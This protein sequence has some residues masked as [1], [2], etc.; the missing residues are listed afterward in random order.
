MIEELAGL[1]GPKVAM[2]SSALGGYVNCTSLSRTTLNYTVGGRGRLCGL[3]VA[4]VATIMLV[5]DPSFL[6]VV[7]KFVVGGLLLYLGLTLL[8]VWV[9][10][11][12][13]RLSRIEYLSLLAIVLIIIQWGFIAGVLIGVIIGCLTFAISASH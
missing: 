12:A 9:V 13:S 2:I 8:K 1:L 6:A 11:S 7:P 10:E 5:A 4:A 3:T